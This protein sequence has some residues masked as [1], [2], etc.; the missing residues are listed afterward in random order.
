MTSVLAFLLTVLG[1]WLLCGEVF[2]RNRL[3]Q[4]TAAGC[5]ALAPML[6]FLA[7]AVMPDSL[8]IGLSTIALWLGARIVRRGVSTRDALALGLVVGLAAVT[9]SASLVLLPPAL[10]ALAVGGL[11]TRAR[12]GS[13]RA[14]LVPIAAWGAGIA[15]TL[16]V[17]VIAARITGRAASGQVAGTAAGCAEP[18]RAGSATS[19]SSTSRSSA[20]CRPTA[21][22]TGTSRSSSTG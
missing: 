14:A 9:K 2:A 1:T 5:V 3:L 13:L 19:G 15:A 17:W 6:G 18:A 11:R 10:L 20:S 4:T 22:R 7:G 12:A 16:G 21:A 8:V